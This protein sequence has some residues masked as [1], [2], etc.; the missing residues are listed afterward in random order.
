ME[1]TMPAPA[2][3]GLFGSP[4]ARSGL[5][6]PSSTTDNAPRSVAPRVPLASVMIGNSLTSPDVHAAL[7]WAI[8]FPQSSGLHSDPPDAEALL[9]G[10]I[11]EPSLLPS[12]AEQLGMVQA[13]FGLSKSL[14]AKACRVQRQ[15]IYDWYAGNFEAEDENAE[16]LLRLFEL[17]EELRG[18]GLTPLSASV[19]QRRRDDGSGLASL[20]TAE[21]I[22]RAA[23]LR[24]CDQLGK[25]TVQRR[26]RGAAALRRRLGWAEPDE[27]SRAETL[28]ANLDSLVDG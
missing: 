3:A 1:M 24:L 20:L 23:I 6:G 14:L 8:L 22:D 27:Q 26:D 25:A 15:T 5:T 19:A 28:A 18:S 21:Q 7:H 11:R 9:A 12:T 16:R 17:T 2:D 10:H 13:F 4:F